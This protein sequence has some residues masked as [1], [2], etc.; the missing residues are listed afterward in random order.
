MLI[1]GT[2]SWLKVLPYYTEGEIDIVIL[3]ASSFRK[4]QER[5]IN[6]FMITNI[7]GDAFSVHLNT[8]LSMHVFNIR[9]HAISM[10]RFEYQLHFIK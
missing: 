1:K 4:L 9:W 7:G 5:I 6:A 10:Y 3:T 2:K 8:T